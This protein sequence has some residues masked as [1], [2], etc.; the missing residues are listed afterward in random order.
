MI[1]ATKPRPD[2]R[3]RFREAVDSDDA[4]I[5]E[6]LRIRPMDGLIRLALTREPDARIAAAAEGERH[7]ALV[8]EDTHEKRLMSIASR[9]VRRVFLGG[10]ERLVGYLGQLRAVE[11]A[12]ALRRLVAGYSRMA[13]AHQADEVSFDLTAILADNRPA[14][15]LLERGLPGLPRYRPLDE[16]ETLVVATGRAKR[17]KAVPGVR[18]LS[19]RDRPA[20]IAFLRREM[21]RYAFGP[22]WRAEDFRPQGRLRNLSIEDTFAVEDGG[23]FVAVGALWDQREYKQAVVTGYA[24][25]LRALRPLA[26]VALASVGQPLLPPPGSVLPM[27]FLTAF[28]VADDAPEPAFLL[29]EALRREA[30]DRGLGQLVFTLAQP[31]PLREPLRK[32]FAARPFRSILYTVHWDGLGVAGDLSHATGTALPFVEAALL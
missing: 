11:G 26:N 25:W 13:L 4:P 24:P 5:R 3:Y 1:A 12:C 15:R 29:V 28:A 32:R 17:R 10:E 18:R 21:R 30:R 27:A 7:L 19:T 2:G 6:L 8:L 14:R 22:V 20:L 9:S 31:H 23:R 16:V